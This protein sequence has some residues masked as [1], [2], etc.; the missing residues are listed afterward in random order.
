VI[1]KSAPARTCKECYENLLRYVSPSDKKND[2]GKNGDLHAS[3]EERERRGESKDNPSENL[4][5]LRADGKDRES[6]ETTVRRSSVFKAQRVSST[7]SGHAGKMFLGSLPFLAYAVGCL[8]LSSAYE[9]H[10][11]NVRLATVVIS[12]LA[13]LPFF[14]AVSSEFFLSRDSRESLEVS[15]PEASLLSLPTQEGDE[16]PEKQEARGSERKSS[17]SSMPVNLTSEEKEYV[18]VA[19]RACDKLIRE[20]EADK[21][22]WIEKKNNETCRVTMGKMSGI[23]YNVFKASALLNCSINRLLNLVYVCSIN[24]SWNPNYKI[25]RRI[26]K[27]GGGVELVYVQTNPIGPISSRD[28]VSV[29]CIRRYKGGFVVATASV[30]IKSIGPVSGIVRAYN[31][32][33][34]GFVI[35]PEGKSGL[36]SR[37]TNFMV[38]DIKGWILRSILELTVGSALFKFYTQAIPNALAGEWGLRI[39][40]ESADKFVESLFSRTGG[41]PVDH[42][43]DRKRVASESKRKI[44]TKENIPNKAHP[45]ITTQRLEYKEL[46]TEQKEWMKMGDQSMRKLLKEVEGGSGDWKVLKAKEDVTIYCGRV[47]G[48]NYKI[49]KADAIIDA[50]MD[51]VFYLTFDAEYASKNSDTYNIYER[52]MFLGDTHEVIYLQTNAIGAISPRDEVQVRTWKRYKGGYA[53]ASTTI[54][55]EKF[56]PARGH[57][58]SHTPYGAGFTLTPVEGEPGKCRMINFFSA[59]IKGWV[60][61]LVID[62]TVGGEMFKFF[63]TDLPAQ[64]EDTKSRTEEEDSAYIRQYF[65]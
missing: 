46:N 49:F 34:G 59:D 26:K 7:G 48:I 60:P 44:E 20:Y 21:S 36:V 27:L 65:K 28:Q 39:S 43:M 10:P 47:S 24:Q 57:V 2:P 11:E 13:S 25:M 32:S 55:W 54:E 56:P 16:I 50:P 42:A 1:N 37:M 51:R 31:P 8:L 17:G 58:R 53:L 4:A 52:Q 63:M 29:R 30:E 23:P 14:W 18:E 33:G 5:V 15:T 19:N 6:E 61:R 45:L 41:E 64:L 62:M 9:L 40:Q 38:T 35:V 12:I 3:E 22:N